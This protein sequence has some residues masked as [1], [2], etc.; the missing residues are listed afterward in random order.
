MVQ[1]SR[2]KWRFHVVQHAQ[3]IHN[4]PSLERGSKHPSSIIHLSLNYI[5]QAEAAILTH[6]RCIG[7][8]GSMA[9]W[10]TLGAAAIMVIQAP[11]LLR[12]L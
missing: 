2:R 7:R 1:C 3:L 12:A 10:C 4:D 9:M 6:M 8:G 5:T 11:M